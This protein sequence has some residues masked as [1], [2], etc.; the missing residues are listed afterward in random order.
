[1]T[2]GCASTK[3]RIEPLGFV[4]E[5]L[6]PA[7]RAM[8][9][10]ERLFPRAADDLF[11]LREAIA[12]LAQPAR[13]DVPWTE[14]RIGGLPGQPDVRLFVVNAKP[15]THRPAVLHMHGGGFVAGRASDS[16]AM[17]QGMAAELDCAFVTVDYRLAPESSHEESL[18][19]NYAGLLWLF[20]HAEPLGVDPSR[21]A[22]M[23][24]SAGGGHAALLAIAARDRGDVS[25]A[26]QLLVYPML[27]DR[28]GTDRQ[29]EPPVGTLFWTAADNAF[30]WRA[31]LGDESAQERRRCR[32]VP[33]RVES[34]A[35]LP[36]TFICVGSI[37][38]FVDECIEF[39]AR[40]VDSGVPTELLVTAGAFHGFDVVAPETESAARFNAAKIA[41]LNRA[42]R[43]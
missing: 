16:I 32:G 6:R 22:V 8:L 19:D 20:E 7:A 38:L 2:I 1:M 12:R 35:C 17:L 11:G 13:T 42:L 26:F 9:E 36:P 31:F 24:E 33:A 14:Q 41:A 27:D 21:I 10:L 43:P 37:D 25:L 15:G 29:V 39:A 40:L 5:C 18:Q 28:T 30:G 3:E 4:A 34:V 23:G